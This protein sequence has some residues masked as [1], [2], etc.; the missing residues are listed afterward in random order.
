MESATF[1]NKRHVLDFKLSD[2]P[3][4]SHSRL[5]SGLL[6]AF[7]RDGGYLKLSEDS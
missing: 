1:V 7:D 4:A 3:K 6:Q 2:W 5:H